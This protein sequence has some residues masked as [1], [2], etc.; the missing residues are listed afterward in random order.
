MKRLT[1]LSVFILILYLFNI[2]KAEERK[3][4]IDL[5][6]GDLKRFE[7]YLLSGLATNISYYKNKLI[8]IDVVVVVHGNAY[9]FFI[10]DLSK[11]PYKEEKQ[12]IKKQYE[13]YQRLK[14]L[15][16]IYN[17]KFQICEAGLKSRK[18]DLKNIYD[19]VKPVYTVF[20]A[21]VDLQ[22]K[23]YAYFPIR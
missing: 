13:I 9:K 22:N 23:G 18:I 8:D 21:L 4:V 5:T 20:V 15:H 1:V 2:T 11:S 14:S 10:K 19:F 16:D 3:V 7:L 12:L 6:T 17:V